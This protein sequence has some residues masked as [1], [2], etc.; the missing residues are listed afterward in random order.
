MR[1]SKHLCR[2]VMLLVVTGAVYAAWRFTW[3]RSPSVDYPASIDLGAQTN[4]DVA[5]GRITISNNGE[6]D[7]LITKVR[8]E[9][10]CTGL[11]LFR[12]NLFSRFDELRIPPRASRELA[13]RVAIREPADKS[14]RTKVWFATND[15]KQPLGEISIVVPKIVGLSMTPTSVVFGDLLAGSQARQL[16]EVRDVGNNGYV[17]VSVQS[18][19]PQSISA[20]LLPVESAPRSHTSDEA[21]RLIGMISVTPNAPVEG[22]LDATLQVHLVREG[23]A[24]T[25]EIRT[26]GRIVPPVVVSPSRITLPR[27]SDSGPSLTATCVCRHSLAKPI[28]VDV[29]FSSPGLSAIVLD[30]HLT[31]TSRLIRIELDASAVNKYRSE[32]RVQLRVFDGEHSHRV[33]ICVDRPL[34]GGKP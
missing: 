25:M 32:K 19:A 15:P 18:S 11:E 21:G 24:E 4:G 30:S 3:R 8:S 34:H 20:C 5:V 6:R 29:E 14:L 27:E 23:R 9:C 28:T 26:S 1:M 10:S 22:S 33:T 17:L 13:V 2:A 7:L 12:D 16:V 31:P